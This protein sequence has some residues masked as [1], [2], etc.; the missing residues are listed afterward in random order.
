MKQIKFSK[1]QKKKQ[2]KQKLKRQKEAENQSSKVLKTV[3]K[4]V[5]KRI[6]R[7]KADAL[8]DDCSIPQAQN[9]QQKNTE[10]DTDFQKLRYEVGKLGAELLERREQRVFNGIMNTSLGGKALKKKRVPKN[11]GIKIFQ[12]QRQK[13]KEWEEEALETG[14]ISKSKL[15]K[16]K[17]RQSGKTRDFGLQ[18]AGRS[19]K[20]GIMRI[21]KN[22]ITKK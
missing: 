17:R 10:K 21:S 22:M 11:I 9:N 15:V 13:Q 16:M 4:K 8:F 2:T 5:F 19:F 14:M 12:Q 3:K 1:L 18:E 7:G 20:A 6:N